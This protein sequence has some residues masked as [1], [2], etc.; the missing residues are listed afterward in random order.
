[1]TNDDWYGVLI[2]GTNINVIFSLI[3][4]LSMVFFLNYITYGLV[5]AILLDGFG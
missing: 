3:Y 1:M 4:S 5:M 2:L